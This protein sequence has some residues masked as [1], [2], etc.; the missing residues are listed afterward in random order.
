MLERYLLRPPA[1]EH[2]HAVFDLILRCDQRDIGFADS[3][4]EDLQHDWNSIDLKKDAWLALDANGQ[5]RGYAACVPWDDGIQLMIYD[6][7]GTESTDLFQGLLLF[8]GLRASAILREKNDP[9]KHSIHFFLYDQA[10][11]QNR[12]VIEAGY[13]IKKYIF[14]MHRDLNGDLPKPAFPEGIRIRNPV[15]GQDEQAIHA[16]VQQAFD[17]RD[18]TPQP[19]EEWKDSLMRPEIYDEKLW[20]LAMQGD[21]LIGTCLCMKRSTMGWVR[22]LAV[23]KSLRKLGIGRALLEHAF[24]VFKDLG[25]QKVGLAVESENPNAVHF[26][27]TAGMYKAVHLN[28]YVRQ[29]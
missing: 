4:I 24:L 21:E 13:S 14:N 16:F 5:L 15:T 1:R 2:E 17:W 8:S 22:Q 26:Y 10:G 12:V 3:D 19:F 29:I 28:E 27:E 7:P 20:F 6:D 9:L 25:F 23:K 11:F 18:R